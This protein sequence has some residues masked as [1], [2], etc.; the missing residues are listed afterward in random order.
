MALI[1]RRR[2]LSLE[3][4]EVLLALLGGVMIGYRIASLYSQITHNR[5]SNIVYFSYKA[6][7]NLK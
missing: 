1:Y 6:R 5:T 7:H 4:V 2:A 3:K